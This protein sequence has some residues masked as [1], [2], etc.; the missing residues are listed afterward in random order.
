[1][2]F[3]VDLILRVKKTKVTRKALVTGIRWV[4]IN[5]FFAWAF[6]HTAYLDT[7]LIAWGTV[8]AMNVALFVWSVYYLSPWEA[9]LDNQHLAQ[10]NSLRRDLESFAAEVGTGVSSSVEKPNKTVKFT[11]EGAVFE[12]EYQPT[13][14][15][16]GAATGCVGIAKFTLP[17]PTQYWFYIRRKSRF[18][19]RRLIY[20]RVCQDLSED[21]SS[22]Y[23]FFSSD[24]QILKQILANDEVKAHLTRYIKNEGYLKEVDFNKRKFKIRCSFGSVY[25]WQRAADLKKTIQ[26]AVLFYELVGKSEI[27]MLCR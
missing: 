21:L 6:L 27:K 13:S 9:K 3:L 10:M 7:N 5:T 4:A 17:K 1:M 12:G 25:Y 22:V 2:D 23:D 18:Q 8:A 26:T 14:S 11:K 19:W 15:E 24:E 20:Q 16:N